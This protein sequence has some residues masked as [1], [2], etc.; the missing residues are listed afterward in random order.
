MSNEKWTEHNMFQCF[1]FVH[2]LKI[3]CN[4]NTSHIHDINDDEGTILRTGF[5]QI[6]H[7][8]SSFCLLSSL[9][10]THAANYSFRDNHVSCLK[11]IYMICPCL[12]KW[13]VIREFYLRFGFLRCMSQWILYQ[14]SCIMPCLPRVISSVKN[15][16]NQYKIHLVS[17][18][19][20]E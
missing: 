20:A 5:D 17:V 15:V 1:C 10:C 4:K 13:L 19:K 7:Y 8:S 6:H 14:M 12:F 9:L 2:Q 18:S 3:L 16:C 11:T